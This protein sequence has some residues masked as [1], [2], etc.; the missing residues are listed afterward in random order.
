MKHIIVTKDIY[1]SIF[2]CENC[3]NLTNYTNSR[4]IYFSRNIYI[5]HLNF[6]KSCFT[7]CIYRS[8]IQFY[9]VPL[10]YLSFIYFTLF[11]RAH[12]ISLVARDGVPGGF[13]QEETTVPSTTK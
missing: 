11:L 9:D 1:I 12:R 4:N 8:F 3:E 7:L 2:L 10:I 5:S 13:R 6:H